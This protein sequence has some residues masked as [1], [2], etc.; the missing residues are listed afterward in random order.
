MPSFDTIVIGAGPNGLAAAHRLAKSGAKVLLLEAAAIPGGGAA[1]LA[2]LSYNLDPRVAEGMDLARHGLSWAATALPTTALAEDGNH[3]RLD[4]VLGERL[5]GP[6]NAADI[7]AWAELRARLLRFA[8]VLAPLNTMTPPRPAADPANP[9]LK[10][11]KIGLKAR[12]MGAAEFRELGRI[13]LT[14]VFDLLDDELSSPLLK[15][16][17]AFDATL[18]S[19]LGPRSPNSVLPWL[20][21][22][23]GS[24]DGKQAAIGLPKGGMPALAKAMAKAATAAGVTIRCNARVA[25][26]DVEH[27]T[28]TGVT[29]A[30]GEQITAR[31]IVSTLAPKVTLTSLINPRHLDAGLTTR[32]R[33]QKARGGAARLDLTLSELPD[34]RGADLTH[35][36]LIAPSDQHVERAFNPVKY[37]EVPDR[38]VMEILI[39]TAH[40]TTTEHQLSAVVQ[41]APHAPADRDAA[42]AAMLSACLAQL[43]RHAPGIGARITNASI[44]MPYDIE[45]ETGLPGGN[46]HAGELTVEQMLFLRPLPG[47]AQYRTPISGLWLASAGCHPGG[48]VSGTPGWNAALAMEAAR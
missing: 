46:W 47:I 33:H 27:G 24:T 41:Y 12:M 34:F 8:A 31:R 32:A 4:G 48:G 28:T 39:P 42:R 29:L 21:R 9:I 3:L 43:E 37:G 14:N 11:A 7:K 40:S 36:L 22:L 25:T 38:P 20:Y 18:G 10:L 23:S 15:G 26:I 16:A 30:D 1:T 44:R 6:V 13:F 17:L 5:S 19:W 45:A 35:R 2:H